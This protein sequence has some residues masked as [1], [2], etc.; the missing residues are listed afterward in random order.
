MTLRNGGVIVDVTKMLYIINALNGFPKCTRSFIEQIYKNK[1]WLQPK[2]MKVHIP[3]CRYQALMR[4]QIWHVDIHYPKASWLHGDIIIYI[5]INLY[6]Y[7][8]FNFNH[9]VS[10]YTHILY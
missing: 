2:K 9:Y 4:N 5:I 3:R 6:L 1:G 7:K 10:Y 8:L